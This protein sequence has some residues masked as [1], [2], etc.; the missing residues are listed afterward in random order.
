M[1]VGDK[2]VRVGEKLNVCNVSILEQKLKMRGKRL[3]NKAKKTNK[4]PLSVSFL[5]VSGNF[6]Q[7]QA[8][9]EYES[10]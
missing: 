5:A 6:E 3:S 4:E 9:F 7:S 10:N 2:F 1:P 8:L